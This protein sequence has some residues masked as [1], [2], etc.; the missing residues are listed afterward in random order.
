MK[1]AREVLQE[2]TKLSATAQLVAAIL[3]IESL[4]GFASADLRCASEQ[5]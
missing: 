5:F 2:F 3:G 4:C 1:S